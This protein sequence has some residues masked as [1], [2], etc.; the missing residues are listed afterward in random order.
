[1]LSDKPYEVPPYLL[2]KV[3]GRARV[4]TAVAGADSALAL[5][6]AQAA[7]EAGVIE[8]VLAGDRESIADLARSAGWDI[9]PFE[10]IDTNGEAGAA[11]AAVR[12][13][14]EGR[15]AMLMKGQVHTD[16][17]MRAVIDREEGLRT[18]KRLSHIFHMTVPGSDRVLHITDAAVN[19]APDA[20]TMM[21]IIANA[22]ELAQRLGTTE[23]R[24]AVL[25]A[26]ETASDAMPSSRLAETVV[27]RARAGEVSGAQISGPFA[28]DNAV[29][30]Q[31]AALKG[32]DDPVAG[33]ADILVV[34]NIETGNGLFKMM[35]WFM[36]ATAAGVVMGARVPIVLTSRADPPEAR[37]SAAIVAALIAEN[38][39]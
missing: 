20:N 23:P 34:P 13:V 7:T 12:T 35:V 30:P 38:D 22:V 37:L 4:R 17:L 21:H 28:F 9:S 14:R 32:I 10:L 5:E 19:V 18:G 33:K 29:A 6:S 26:T 31:A 1:M 27:A 25:S 3:R 2:E 36:G 16:T 8:P 39:G 11:A 15:A 24:V